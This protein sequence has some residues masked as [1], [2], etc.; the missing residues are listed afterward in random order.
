MTETEM[1][2]YSGLLFAAG[3]IGGIPLAR[4]ESFLEWVFSLSLITTAVPFTLFMIP[5]LLKSDGS[6]LASVIAA[7]FLYGP[8][9]LLFFGLPLGVGLV[10]S[11]TVTKKVCKRCSV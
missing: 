9:F 2:I 4:C 1:F 5:P 8:G 10:L 3:L 6:V 7:M 11:R